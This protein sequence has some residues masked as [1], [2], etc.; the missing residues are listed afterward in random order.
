MELAECTQLLTVAMLS[1]ISSSPPREG[2]EGGE[3]GEDLSWD[4]KKQSQRLKEKEL[5][6]LSGNPEAAVKWVAN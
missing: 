4:F 6:V 3:G 2:G 1:P 5:H